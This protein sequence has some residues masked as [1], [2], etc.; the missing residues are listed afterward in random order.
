M[1]DGNEDVYSMPARPMW[2]ACRRARHRVA[3]EREDVVDQAAKSSRSVPSGRSSG[4]EMVNGKE[5]LAVLDDSAR[6][7]PCT[8]TVFI[9]ARDKTFLRVQ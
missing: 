2:W 8:R 7:E 6:R 3:H 9:L 1:A 4:R 5:P